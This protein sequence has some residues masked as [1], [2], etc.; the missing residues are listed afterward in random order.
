MIAK[1]TEPSPVVE[2]ALSARLLDK[3]GKVIASK[4][5]EDSQKLNN[6]EPTAA[7]AAF[8]DTFD[9]I[10]RDMIGWTVQAL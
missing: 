10:A 5:F 1:A 6:V 3:N 4:L 7:V 9:R 2:I 8:S